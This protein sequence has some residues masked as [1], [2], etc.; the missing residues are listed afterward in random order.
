MI[1]QFPGGGVT[2]MHTSPWLLETYAKMR[3]DPRIGVGNVMLWQVADTPITMTRNK[4]L[5]VAEQQGVDFVLMLDN[6][7]HFD[8]PYG[9][10]KPFWDEAF[11]FAINHPGPCVIGAPYCGPPPNE[12]VYVFR[13]ENTQ[14]DDPNPNFLLR[15][16]DRHHAATLHG[17]QRVAALPTGLM[18]IDMRAVKVLPH[19]RFYYEWT[20]TTHSE[21]ASTED[22][23]FSRDLTYA[24]VPLY[25]TWDSWAGH[26]KPK[27]VAKPQ[28]IPSDV[29]PQWIAERAAELPAN[30]KTSLAQ[31]KEKPSDNYLLSP[32]P[33][34]MSYGGLSQDARAKRI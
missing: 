20:D 21:K 22:V 16:Y 11:P 24:G 27:M 26:I 9:D 25:C 2:T 12:N 3:D 14:S 29:V 1:A 32:K 7:M 33:E 31:F 4:C 19:P 34:M 23:T 6:D 30:H 8:L 28:E 5:V 17:I 15:P 18:L 13:F 10:A